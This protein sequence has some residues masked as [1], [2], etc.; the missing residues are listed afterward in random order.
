MKQNKSDQAN[1]WIVSTLKSRLAVK[2]TEQK[3]TKKL[4]D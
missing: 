3:Y 2:K 4:S 1:R